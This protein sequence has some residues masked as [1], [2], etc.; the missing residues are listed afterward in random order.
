MHNYTI[1]QPKFCI[2]KH[3]ETNAFIP[4][5]KFRYHKQNKCDKPNALDKY[6]HK[7]AFFTSVFR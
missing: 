6:N 2:Q 3:N 4:K 5:I 7:L 1:L